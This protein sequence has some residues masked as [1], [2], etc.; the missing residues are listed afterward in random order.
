MTL[1]QL[2]IVNDVGREVVSSLGEV[3]QLQFRDVSNKRMLDLLPMGDI[4]YA[5][6]KFE[7]LAK[8]RYQPFPTKVYE[9]Y[10]SL[11]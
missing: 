2:Y 9:R 4:Q 10:T 8:S 11:G 5:N 7:I 3:G 1:I 6:L